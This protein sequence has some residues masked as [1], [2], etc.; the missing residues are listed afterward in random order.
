MRLL[1]QIYLGRQQ[2]WLRCAP[3]SRQRI[4]LCDARSML[5]EIF[6]VDGVI[7]GNPPE[8]TGLRA[9]LSIRAIPKPYM[10]FSSEIPF[11]AFTW[12]C[13]IKIVVCAKYLA[14]M[15]MIVVYSVRI[16]SIGR[17]FAWCN[18]CSVHKKKVW[19]HVITRYCIVTGAA[20]SSRG[21]YTRGR[22]YFYQL[23]PPWMS[24]RRA[25][26]YIHSMFQK[27]CCHFYFCNIIGYFL[28]GWLILVAVRND[29]RT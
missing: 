23:T 14:Y 13:Q 15:R 25:T 1:V 19:A 12:H 2:P 11:Q 18:V 17:R 9:G 28:L 7:R 24:R 8:V 27:N 4:R 3:W 16:S 22:P 5:S 10:H 21:P 29:Q 6:V 20:S 26:L